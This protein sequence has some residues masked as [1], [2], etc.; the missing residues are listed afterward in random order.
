M[1]L[2][3]PTLLVFLAAYAGAQ[4]VPRKDLPK[5]MGREVTITEPEKADADGFFPKGP[6][7][8]CI[9]APPKRQC[10]TAPEMFGNSPTVE[11]VQLTKDM[12]ALLFSAESPGVSGWGIHF[13]LLRPGTGENLQDLLIADGSVSNQSQHVMWNDS[14]ISD[15]PIFLT[16]DFIWG[17]D[18]GH[19]GEHR[20]VISAYVMKRASIADDPTYY[21]E[22]R[23][24][25]LHRYDYEKVD[26]LTSEKQEILARLARV[27]AETERQKRTRLVSIAFIRVHLRLGLLAATF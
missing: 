10:Y 20:Y 13:A 2:S 4:A 25:T 5:F 23:F 24:M 22:D 12:P 15:A 27:K 19:Y 18:E 7:S 21:L 3:I 17:S 6:A 14:A 26:I 16:A 1:K 9:E 11:L 8:V